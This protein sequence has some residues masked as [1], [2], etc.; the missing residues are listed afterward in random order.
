MRRIIVFSFLSF[1]FFLSGACFAETSVSLCNVK[2]S[3]HF[4]IYFQ[5]EPAGYTD[6]IIRQAEDY[7]TSLL[8]RLGFDRFDDFWTWDKRCKIYLYPSLA[9]Y[10]KSAGQPEWSKA[11]VNVKERVIN[12]FLFEKSFID[13]LLPHELGH[14]IF[15]EFI[16]YKAR[17]P[18]WIDEGVACLQEKGAQKR[19]EFASNAVKTGQFI[20]LEKLSAINRE[21]LATPL[22][23]YAEATSVVHFLLE[24]YGKEK[25]TDYCRKLRDYNNKCPWDELLFDTYGFKDISRMDYEWRFFL[26]S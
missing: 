13:V 2:K 11:S 15:R 19:L 3:Q 20:P 6:E 14:L 18:L 7:Y 10:K 12:S 24:K 17:L 21:N 26:S 4:I 5:E 9:D 25:F 16:G 8:D 1:F 22:I 23:F